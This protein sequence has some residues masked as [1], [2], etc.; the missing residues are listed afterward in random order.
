MSDVVVPRTKPVAADVAIAVAEL[1]EGAVFPVRVY[2]KD[3]HLNKV[4]AIKGGH[5]LNDASSDPDAIERLWQQ[6]G[7]FAHIG[8]NCGKSDLVVLDVDRPEDMSREL[9][10]LLLLDTPTLTFASISR[11]LPHHVFRGAVKSRPIACGDIKSLGGFVVL[12]IDGDMFDAPIADWTPDLEAATP[13]V[14]PPRV[15]GRPRPSTG[16]YQELGSQS[17]SFGIEQLEA[18]A[19]SASIV[20]VGGRHIHLYGTSA[21]ACGHL[22]ARGELTV[23]DA[24]NVLPNAIQADDFPLREALL[25]T[26]DGVSKTVTEYRDYAEAVLADLDERERLIKHGDV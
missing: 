11:G 13:V 8:V 4:P 12:S 20:P 26:I 25:T 22:I 10:L 7:G 23:D 16:D 5:G 9:S 1:L 24:L 2:A 14:R 3:G 17:S 21:N 18:I 19:F 15:D 6:A